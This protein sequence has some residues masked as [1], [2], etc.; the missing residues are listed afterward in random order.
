MPT[1]SKSTELLL[2]EGK[3]HLTKAEIAY[4]QSVEKYLSTKDNMFFEQPRVKADKIAHQEFMRLR[5]LYGK[6]EFVEALDQQII[7][8][9]CLEVSNT[10]QL[11][12]VLDRLYIDLDVVKQMEDRLRIYDLIH[13][14]G[15]AMNKNKELLLKYED[16]LFLNPATRLKAVPKT[17]PKEEKL[18]GMAAFMANRAEN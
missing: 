10:Q 7:N 14:A 3:S 1:P 9:Y 13:K 11:Q 5:R 6:I 17:P 4:R 2:L 16:R 18:T 15:I 12:A 8:R